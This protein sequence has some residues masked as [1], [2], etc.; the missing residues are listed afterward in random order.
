MPRPKCCRL[1]GAVPERKCFRPE[2]EISSGLDEVMLSLDEYEALR[3]ADLEGLY[4]EEAASRMNVSRQTFGR[5][6][7]AAR[8]KVADVL[9]NGKALRIEGG[10]VS[11]KNGKHFRCPRCHKAFGLSGEA[12]DSTTC[13]HCTKQQENLTILKRRTL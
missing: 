1:V 5:I 8:R 13:P 6:V 9:V 4:Q 7:E 12:Q 3:L 11:F 2:G 10:I